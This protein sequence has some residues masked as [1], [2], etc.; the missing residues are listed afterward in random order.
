MFE[1]Y[2]LALLIILYT[3]PAI[4]WNSFALLDH[5]RIAITVCFSIGTACSLSASILILPIIRSPSGHATARRKATTARCKE[6]QRPTSVCQIP[7]C[8]QNP[9][10]VAFPM[11][12][13]VLVAEDP[14]PVAEAPVPMAVPEPVPEP[15]ASKPLG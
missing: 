9:Q 8:S 2:F 6:N 15:K 13:P 3:L 12:E 11:P 10:P 5:P 7:P 1:G 14:V 4:P